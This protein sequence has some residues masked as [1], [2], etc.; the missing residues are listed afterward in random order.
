[1]HNEITR[2]KAVILRRQG[3]SIIQIAKQL[4]IAKSTASLWTKNIKLP[5]NLRTYLN[6]NS[7]IGLQKGSKILQARREILNKNIY[8][9]AK[10]II[11]TI[12]LLK[13]TNYLQIIAATIFWCE[14]GKRSLSR[15]QLTNSDPKLIRT[16]LHCLRKSFDLDE[17]KFRCL[18][19]IH[20]YH[21]NKK[22]LN[23]WSQTT[24]IPLRQFSKSYLKKNTQ[25]RKRENYEGCLTIRYYDSRIAK[26]LDAIY[27]AF[28]ENTE[29][30]A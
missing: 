7:L 5:Q 25:I 28:A 16:F 10:K 8:Q 12:N 4:G 9:D 21:D 19:H 1:M 11:D 29:N 30:N 18:L 6:Q 26:K 20:N 14:G 2:E 17:N 24:N 27:H 3:I 22:Q 15:L 23:F 13:N